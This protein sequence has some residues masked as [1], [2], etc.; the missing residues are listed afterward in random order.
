MD[1]PDAGVDATDAGTGSADAGVLPDAGNDGRTDGGIW[2]L[3]GFGDISGICNVLDDELTETTPSYFANELDFGTNGWDSTELSQLTDGGQEIVSDGNAGGS[4]LESEIFSYEMLYRCEGAT[5][6]K[7]ET[8]VLYQDS[9]GKITDLLV[10]IDGMKVGVSVTRAVAFPFENPYSVQQAKALLEGKLQDIL[11]S[12]ARVA[13]EDAWVK[14]ILYV[15][16]YAP[17]HEDSL[18][19]AF[20][21]I[22]PGIKA[23][24]ILMVTVTNG[25]DAFIY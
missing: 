24:T 7:T 8:E 4:S 12:S 1:D 21:Q 25:D 10:E 3:A 5:L 23:D 22:D 2:P 17:G 15:M 11:L 18:Q 20:D 14:Q 16:A 9:M 19:T 13:P 6:L